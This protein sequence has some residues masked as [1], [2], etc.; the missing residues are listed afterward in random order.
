LDKT[1]RRLNLPWLVVIALMVAPLT[2]YWSGANDLPFLWRDKFAGHIVGRDFIN[3]WMGAR[4]FLAHQTSTLFDPTAYSHAVEAT[5]GRGF[6]QLSF[7]YP[8]SILPLIAWLGVLPYHVALAAWTLLGLLALFAAAWPYSRNPWIAAAILVS[9]AVLSCIDDGQNGLF[10]GAALVTALTRIDRRPL[11]A[12]VLIGLLTFKPQLGILLPIALLAARRWKVIASA[13]VTA[14]G[15]FALSLLFAGVEAWRLYLA[16]TVPFQ[17][18]LFQ[19][20]TGMWRAMTPSPA[21]ATVSAGGSWHAAFMV[22]A[23]V[24]IAIVFAIAILFAG[25]G[26]SKR[27]F[28]DVDRIVLIGAGY[29]ASPYSF[30]Y[31]MPALAV[32]LLIASASRPELD[33]SSAW[34]WGGTLLWVAPIVMVFV[35]LW[36]INFHETWP[37]VGSLMIAS[38][39]GLV[40]WATR[41]ETLS[42]SPLGPLARRV[43][44]WLAPPSISKS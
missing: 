16:K 19:Q 37:P 5:W 35:G 29:L 24:S 22:Q 44:T 13:G 25:R 31:D 43:A 28:S 41:Q 38:G 27:P 10:T 8:P 18:Y 23:L 7:S 3:Y 15:L 30:S 21:M 11:L 9:P 34:R 1:E 12:G 4:L 6:G 26:A 20:T 32:C 33:R 40:L 17:G 14:I 42:D 39:L 36:G 2:L